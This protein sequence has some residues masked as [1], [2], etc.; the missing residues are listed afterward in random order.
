MGG[1]LLL[2]C[3]ALGVLIGPL[4][5]VGGTTLAS[6]EMAAFLP[7]GQGAAMADSAIR[8]GIVMTVTSAAVSYTHLGRFAFEGFLS[9]NKKS[10]REHLQSLSGERRTM[11]FYEAPHKLPGTL[12]DLLEALGDRRVALARE[13]T[14]V[15]EEVIRTTLSEAAARCV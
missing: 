8:S 5:I 7:A 2:I 12:R 13:L 4:S 9:V 14:K 6:P 3:A 1:I 10:R 15:H 11:V